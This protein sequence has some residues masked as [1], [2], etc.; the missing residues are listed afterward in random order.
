MA[1]RYSFDGTCQIEFEGLG[2][3]Q[4]PA[5][6]LSAAGLRIELDVLPDEGTQVRCAIALPNG[7]HWI[8]GGN[9]ARVI[10]RAKSGIAIAFE[11]VTSF[12]RAQLAAAFG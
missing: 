5:V 12:D 9:V 8:V 3:V 7:A 6:N 11:G 4:A 2:R 10:D 1:P